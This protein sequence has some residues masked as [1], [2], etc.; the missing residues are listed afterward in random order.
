[1]DRLDVVVLGGGIIGC[2][3]AE[4]LARRGQRVAVVERGR[5]GAEASSA[6]AGIL[7][8][9]MDVPRPGPFFDLCQVARRMYP[10]WVAHLERG[11]GRSVG[12]QADGS[13]FLVDTPRGE[14]AMARQAR[15][16][17]SRGLRVER[18]SPAQVRR[19]EP[20]VD[21]RF[22]CGWFFPA[23][24]QVDNVALMAALAL[25]CRAAGVSL[26]ERT[27]VRRLLIRAGRVRGVET[28][29][30]PLAAPVVV[31]CLGSWAALGGNFPVRLPV[32]PARGQILVFQAPKRFVHRAVMSPHAYLVQRRDGRLL[33]G[34]TIERVGF[35]KALT[36]EGMAGILQG[37]QRMSRAL[38]SCTF[39]GAWAG[40]RPHTPDQKPILG[41]TTVEGLYVATGH[42]R[43]G[44]LLAP[45]TATCMADLILTGRAPFPPAPFSLA[46]FRC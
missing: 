12:F 44:I 27:V 4:E 36:L 16:Q 5:V 37:A 3:L 22:R 10:S 30:G 34:S 38:D 45:V 33:V 23:E 25:A 41:R 8:A 13:L 2:A 26:R 46:R 18:W 14:A 15:W 9:Q 6:A 39:L 28:D 21:G 19:Q 24:A 40:F 1:M 43:H 42:F 32:E 31:N 29:G 17:R 11:L 7:A 20:V 35:Q